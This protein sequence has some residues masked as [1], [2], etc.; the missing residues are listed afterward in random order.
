[1]DKNSK[2]YVAG[3]NGL[4]GSA[5]VR[6]LK[7]KGYNNIL[8]YSSSELDLRIQQDV[9]NMFSVHKPEYVFL[10]AA[11][12]GGILAN[13]SYKA[14]FI[15]DNLAIGMNVIHSAYKFGTEKLISLGSSCI[16][17][18]FCPQPMKEEYLLT[19]TLEPTNEP[20][21]IAKIAA[22]KMCNYYHEQYD[23]NY[24]TLMPPNLYGPGD[25]YNLETSHVLPALVRKI[26]LAKAFSENNIDL[27]RHNLTK[28]NPG[29]GFEIYNSTTNEEITDF[30]RK[31]DI[32]KESI[33]L[34][35]TGK[36]LR[37]FEHSE[38]LANAV[39]FAAENIEASQI[40]DF[41]NVGTGEE[42]SI[43]NLAEMIKKIIRY[44]GS[45]EFSSGE[46]SGTP[47]KVLDNSKALEFG[48]RN[49]ITLENG[50]KSIIKDF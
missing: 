4:V 44:N 42:I 6:E 30:L 7:K 48:I 33:K 32:D 23:C 15:Y 47:R 50:I 3:H 27:I 24:L 21:A 8:T 43:S 17:P 12:V 28:Y 36:E 1:M 40:K 22:L 39:I 49:S 20:Y 5:I 10:A 26:F 31:N 37:E 14:Q 9:E 13:N 45:I 19:G 29:F 11:K 34:W 38:D 25:N 18:K 16:Y 46:L 2:I 41:L 35:G